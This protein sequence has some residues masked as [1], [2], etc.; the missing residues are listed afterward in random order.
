MTYDKL[1]DKLK[2]FLNKPTHIVLLG[3]GS[4]FHGDDYVGMDLCKSLKNKVP[5]KVTIIETGTSP[6]NFTGQLRKI[7]P[8]HIII[9]DAADMNLE[10]GD[11]NLVN[12][13]DI[14]GLS[15]S[16]HHLPLNLFID[17][18]E[19]TMNS[20]VIFIGIQPKSTEFSNSLSPE[21]K[22][23]VLDLSSVLEKVLRETFPS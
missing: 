13:S 7:K 6:E 3:V 2:K 9:V 20:S 12:S 16:T 19:K 15:I 21:L 5:G 8:S 22:K 11:V 1:V 18:I 17:Y 23:T 14:G 4:E 10:P